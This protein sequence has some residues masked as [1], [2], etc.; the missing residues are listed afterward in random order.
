M[1][2]NKIKTLVS[3]SSCWEEYPFEVLEKTIN[4]QTGTARLTAWKKACGGESHLN[5]LL[6]WLELSEEE[7][8]KILGSTQEKEFSQKTDYAET[9]KLILS[10]VPNYIDNIPEF[11]EE[12]NTTVPF[13][14]LI[15]PLVLV[16]RDILL[17]KLEVN[18][19]EESLEK[20]LGINLKAYQQLEYSLLER[21]SKLLR[22]TFLAE[23]SKSKTYGEYVLS[24]LSRWNFLPTKKE[25]YSKFVKH[26]MAEGFSSFF[27]QYPVLGRLTSI[28]INLW[29]DAN[30]EFIGRLK[31]DLSRLMKKGLTTVQEDSNVVIDLQTSLSDPHN[32]GRTVTVVTFADGNKVVYKPKN[33]SLEVAYND[34]LLWLNETASLSAQFK[35][36]TVI[37]RGEYGWCEYIPQSPCFDPQSAEQFYHIAGMLLCL[38]YILHT[39]DCHYEN[40]IATREGPVLI[41]AETIMEHSACWIETDSSSESS[42]LK[43]S[44]DIM[45]NSIV[46][47]GLLP[48]YIPG[49]DGLSVDMSGLGGTEE[50]P[51]KV[52]RV[53]NPNTDAMYLGTE[54][55]T[56]SRKHNVA[57]LEDTPLRANDYT[58]QICAGYSELYRFFI[59]RNSDL[60]SEESPLRAFANCTV[61]FLNRPTRAY[62]KLLQGALKPEYLSDGRDYSLQLTGSL[63]RPYLAGAESKP[64]NL[65]IVKA[66]LEQMGKYLD[67]PFFEAKANSNSLVLNGVEIKD[68][69]QQPSYQKVLEIL[70]GLSEDKLTRDL[71]LI[72]LS[73]HS[74]TPQL[75]KQCN[76]L[77]TSTSSEGIDNFSLLA[78]DELVAEAEL[79]M[80]EIQR[81]AIHD[82]DKGYSYWIGLLYSV[83]LERY[84]LQP[85]GVNL[86]DGS[87]GIALL[88]GALFKVTQNP[89]YKKIS[90]SSLQGILEILNLNERY[91]CEFARDTGI[92]GGIGLGGI[93]YTLTKLG[94]LLEESDL[95]DAAKS[96]EKL[97]TPE[98]ITSDQG[99]DV[100]WGVSGTILSLLALYTVNQDSQ[101]L[102]KAVACGQHL[103]QYAERAYYGNNKLDFDPNPSTGFAH[104]AAALAYSL[105]RLG[106][107]TIKAEFLEAAS[108]L[109]A[110]E[111]QFYNSNLGNWGEFVPEGT[112]Q[113][114]YWSTWCHGA[115]GITLGR[116]ASRGFTQDSLGDNDIEQGLAATVKN[117]LS[118]DHICC[119]EMG[120]C[121]TLLVASKLLS[122]PE[123]YDYA[124][125][126]ATEVVQ[127]ARKNGGYTLFEN[128]ATPVF[129]PSFFKGVS[130]IAYE[131]LRVADPSLP[132]I[133]MWE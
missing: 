110:W 116:L 84:Q 88:A 80:A 103:L 105:A 42:Y 113:Q 100:L 78:N 16:A 124:R 97:I 53:Q 112:T 33:L 133:L 121:E 107:I 11:T 69:F 114:S 117:R 9:L 32:R 47:T 90:I 87:P 57:Y 61:R 130:G 95:I 29:V 91:Q 119:G 77:V 99:Y 96:F 39:T 109:T 123:Y 41:D 129:D 115:P 34:L 82:S 24:V 6:K 38:L 83:Q 67:I 65:P 51:V 52:I 126:L 13:E 3:R 76:Q 49:P 106:A 111:N 63:Y 44:L 8:L 98:L 4:L 58:D 28:V 17:S 1:N 46:I 37:N 18:F 75:Q 64:Y 68:F 71:H 127:K 128:I 5:K 131:L 43:G 15:T 120:R 26:H 12:K 101:T 50:H 72:R 7:A 31:Q 73:F 35:T 45:L 85:M 125:K 59:E 102:D 55:V 104:G 118:V 86:Y 36:V 30:L 92:G 22:E 60:L 2:Q 94:I 66:E 93:I 20:Q 108:K 21:L 40:L 14:E 25:K 27:S 132:S 23:F 56:A 79:I 19:A 54:I 10:K 74:K 70:S 81:Q 48:A 89:D 62:G 122:Q